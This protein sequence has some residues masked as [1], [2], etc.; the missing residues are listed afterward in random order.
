MSADV[1]AWV[2]A[3]RAAQGLPPTV[4]DEP[5]LLEVAGRLLAAHEPADSERT[6]S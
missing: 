1:A 4:E 5:T 2:A 6:A 3:S